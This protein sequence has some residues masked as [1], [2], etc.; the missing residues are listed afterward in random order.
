VFQNLIANGIKFRSEAPP[1]IVISARRRE[2]D[3]LFECTDNGIGIDPEYADRV[4]V[5]FQRLHTR[6][7]YEGTGIGLAMCR[8]IIEFH[9]GEIWLDTAYSG[10]ARIDFT[11][12]AAG[13]ETMVA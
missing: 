5:I 2:L 10:G 4:F 3:W 13:S 12:P 8:K 7:R 11:L 1:R 9:G 6:D